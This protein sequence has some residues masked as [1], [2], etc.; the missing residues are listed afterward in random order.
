MNG[1]IG[2]CLSTSFILTL[3]MALPLDAGQPNDNLFLQS[4][5]ARVEAF[6]SE[7]GSGW[8]AANLTPSPD[9][10]DDTGAPVRDLVWSS[11]SM[12]PFPHWILFRFE[13]P[14]WFTSFVFDNYLVEEPDHPGISAREIEIWSGNTPAGLARVAGF[15]LARNERG[16]AVKVAPF[17]ARF[18]K[19]VVKSN[20]GHPWYTELGATYAFDD[21][22]RPGE[23]TA[24]LLE[25]GAVDLY[26]LYF[27]SGSATLRPESAP[28][29]EAIVAFTTAHPDVR[30]LIEGHTD[31][32]GEESA[33]L[34]LSEARAVAVRD[35]LCRRGV[36][37]ESLSARGFGETHP[38]AD[39]GTETGRA[40][41]RRVT[42]RRVES[43]G[44]VQT[45]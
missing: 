1:S 5:G 20:Y 28:T 18:V 4:Q 37:P 17:E 33:N 35:A 41:N 21:G 13:R 39:D 44:N 9:D 8:E 38:V 22:A 14:T 6:S 7:F 34:K 32:V 2:H 36:K 15:Q 12:A 19:F 10:F 27:D 31:S 43:H 29:L 3:A 30:L 26:G 45:R 24:Q 23:L 42:L 40:A 25:N 11:A 16:Q